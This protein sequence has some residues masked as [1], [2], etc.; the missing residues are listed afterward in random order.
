MSYTAIPAF[1]VDQAAFSKEVNEWLKNIEA[2]LALRIGVGYLGGSRAQAF[3]TASFLAVPDYIDVELDGTEIAGI[4]VRARVEVRTTNTGTSVQPRIVEVDAAGAFVGTLV[5]GAA[6]NTD[7]NWDR[8][9]LTFT[10]LT[11]VH[12]YRLEIIGDNAT[13]NILGIGPGIERFVAPV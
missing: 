2:T 8:Q 7:T 10:P 3:K 5:T 4:T 12:F 11:G 13:N 9:T 6:Y 1:I